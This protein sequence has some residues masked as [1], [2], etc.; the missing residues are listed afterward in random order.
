MSRF[1]N[2]LLQA[3]TW[4]STLTGFIFL[5]M[6][7]GMSSDDPYSVLGHPWQPHFLAAHVLIG[8]AFVF[9]LGLI[10]REHV[11]GLFF[12]DLVPRGRR[13]GASTI[14]LAAPMILSGYLLQVITHPFMRRLLVV[15]HVAAGILFIA[16][17]ALHLAGAARRRRAACTAANGTAGPR[18]D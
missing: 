12:N 2:I 11:V 18:L 1:E 9:A 8:P 4:L 17:F 13:S 16:V 10:S 14:M 15:L 3:T 7:Y 5:V 6:K